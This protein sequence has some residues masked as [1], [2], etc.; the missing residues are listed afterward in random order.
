MGSTYNTTAPNIPGAPIPI[1][2]I[3]QREEVAQFV[4]KAV[5]PEYEGINPHPKSVASCH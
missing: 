5:K 1:L 4:I 2:V 3:G